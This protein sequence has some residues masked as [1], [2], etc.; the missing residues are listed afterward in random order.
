M[1]S[2][3]D[4]AGHPEVAEISDLTEGLLPPSRTSD[5]RQHL[6]ECPLCADV[7]ASLEEIRSMLGTL[8]GP[9]RMPDD[10]AGRIDAA[11]AAEA[12]LNATA[13]D[14]DAS[15]VPNSSSGAASD[16][17]DAVRVSRETSLPAN[18]PAGHSRASTGPGRP[19]STR[20]SRRTTVLAAVFTAAA[21]GLGTL[22]VQSMSGNGSGDDPSAAQSQASDTFSGVKLEKRVADLLDDDKTK[23]APG[24][25]TFGAATIPGTP[26]SSAANPTTKRTTD[27]PPCIAK[28]IGDITTAIAA[29]SGSYQGADAYLVLLSESADTSRVMAYVV[30][31]SCIGKSSEPAGEVLLK[32]SYPRP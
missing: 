31:A 24:R 10:V 19:S 29:E 4:T 12:L 30:D 18:R 2:T 16:E 8:P 15:E 1:T 6:D 20:R 17:H 27:V 3:T 22:L 11:L 13:H 32:Q 21:L 28:G 26:E 25:D 5:V 14:L 9:P 7:Y 23:D